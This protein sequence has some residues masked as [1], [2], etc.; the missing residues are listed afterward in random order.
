[1]QD[2]DEYE[3]P[4]YLETINQLHCQDVQDRI[5]STSA[6][7]GW[8]PFGQEPPVPDY[9]I[10]QVELALQLIGKTVDTDIDNIEIIAQSLDLWNSATMSQTLKEVYIR[11]LDNKN[12]TVRNVRAR[13]WVVE[14]LRA[15]MVQQDVE[16][17]PLVYLERDI[18][19]DLGPPK[20]H[21]VDPPLATVPSPQ[22]KITSLPTREVEVI[23]A[24]VSGPIQVGDIV[25]QSRWFDLVLRPHDEGDK[26]V[27]I[28]DTRIHDD[29][30]LARK[31]PFVDECGCHQRSWRK[32]D[33]Y[34]LVSIRIAVE[35][36]D[37]EALAAV[38]NAK[39]MEDGYC[40]G[41]EYLNG[42][43]SGHAKAGSHVWDATTEQEWQKDRVGIG[44]P[45][46]GVHTAGE[47][48]WR[49]QKFF[50]YSV[51]MRTGCILAFPR[52]HRRRSVV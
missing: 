15:Q 20:K 19:Q 10:S 42:D 45:S 35:L 1:M 33:E 16:G 8:N 9:Q 14:L 40:D 22:R 41:S 51:L 36:S 2:F 46:C 47:Y 29:F 50:W 52:T 7:V 32:R 30:Q 17:R 39:A 34:E 18:L 5:Y 12:H 24:E 49:S 28:G 21:S 6:L 26:F 48:Y 3:F 11:R 13:K 43:D 44:K 37:E 4:S 38:I 31:A 23:A 27:V 25:V